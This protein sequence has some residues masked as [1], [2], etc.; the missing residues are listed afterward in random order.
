MKAWYLVCQTQKLGPRG[1]VFSSIAHSH[2]RGCP[3]PTFGTSH[4]TY[5][6]DKSHFTPSPNFTC[7]YPS[8]EYAWGTT[9]LPV[10]GVPAMRIP[11]R[12]THACAFVPEGAP[13]RRSIS[14]QQQQQQ[15]AHN[16]LGGGGGLLSM[17]ARL[18]LYST[19][20][21]FLAASTHT[22]RS[23]QWRRCLAMS[24]LSHGVRSSITTGSLWAC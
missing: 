20:A 18:A 21:G 3:I 7:S 2:H 9:Y 23:D 10:Y 24:L 6:A 13:C 22:H 4:P 12:Q 8:T 1:A 5:H 17:R 11:F 19:V 16:K 14:R 15:Q